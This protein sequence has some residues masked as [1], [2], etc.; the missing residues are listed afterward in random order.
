MLVRVL[1]RQNSPR[2]A[3][4]SGDT[5]I[6]AGTSSC[7]RPGGNDRIRK[8]VSGGNETESDVYDVAPPKAAERRVKCFGQSCPPCVI[9]LF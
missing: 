3:D 2:P 7:S 8:G 4:D 5:E 1:S 9:S 6:N